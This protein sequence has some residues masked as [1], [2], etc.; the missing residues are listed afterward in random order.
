MPS[1]E[2][3]SALRESSVCLGDEVPS[4]CM[5]LTVYGVYGYESDKVGMDTSI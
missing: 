5:H 4:L 2:L 1:K 3:C